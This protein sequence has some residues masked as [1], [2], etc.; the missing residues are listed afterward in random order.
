[1][2]APRWFWYLCAALI[3]FILIVFIHEHLIIS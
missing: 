1:M 2:M 3:V